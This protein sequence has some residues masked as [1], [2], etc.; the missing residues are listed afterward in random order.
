MKLNMLFVNNTGLPDDQVFIT[1]QDPSQTLEATYVEKSTTVAV[2]RVKPKDMMTKSLSLTKIGKSGLDI[3]NA[4]G[5]VVF[6]S[7]QATPT[8]GGFAMDADL[9]GNKQPSYIG[10]GGANYLKA[11][12]PFEITYV[13]G[14]TGGQ[15]NLTNINY[16][17]APIC[18]QSYNGGVTGTLL[19]TRGYYKGTAAGSATLKSRLADLTKGPNSALATVTNSGKILRYIGPSSYGAGTNPYPNF[20]TYLASLHSNKVTTKIKNSNAFNTMDPPKKGNLNYNYTLD[21]TAT[22]GVD[23]TR[24]TSPLQSR[25]SVESPIQARP[26]PEQR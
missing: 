17:A 9:S 25:R 2:G 12:Q 1:F 14:A 3:A 21:L 10:S 26:I 20:D 19:Q 7:Y 4:E 8:H 18:I 11:Y 16:F 24:E 6:V 13:K 5:P 23:N 22:V 15:G